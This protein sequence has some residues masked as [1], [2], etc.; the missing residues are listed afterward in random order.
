MTR[1]GTTTLVEIDEYKPLLAQLA[2]AQD[3]NA[4]HDGARLR[5]E[6]T[7]ASRGMMNKDYIDLLE[8]CSSK[9]IHP[10]L[11]RELESGI[12]KPKLSF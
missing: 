12:Y 8:S 11:R 2:L 10:A 7:F 4:L 6:D 1:D 9:D 3:V 5:S